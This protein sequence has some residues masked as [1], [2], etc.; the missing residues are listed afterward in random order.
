MA[1]TWRTIQVLSSMQNPSEAFEVYTASLI[2]TYVGEGLIYDSPLVQ[3]VLGGDTSPRDFAV[4]LESE[5]KTSTEGCSEVPLFSSDIYNYA[6]LS[7]AYEKLVNGTAYSSTTLTEL[8]LV[9]VVVD[10]T[11]SLSIQDY[12]VRA[13]NKAGPALL[14]MVTIRSLEFQKYEFVGV[15]NES[16]VELRSVPR[17]PSTES[18]NNVFIAKEHGFY[19]GYEQL[20][21][22][23]TYSLF[24]SIASKSLTHWGWLGESVIADSWA[25]VHCVHCI[26]GLQTVFSLGVLLLVMYQ[27]F[28]T[29]KIWIGDPFASTSTTIFVLRGLLVMATWFVNSFWNLYEFA[30][31]NAAL[32]S[33]SEIVRV[34]EEMVH[35]DVLVHFPGGVILSQNLHARDHRV[36]RAN[37]Q[38]VPAPSPRQRTPTI[39]PKRG[40]YQRKG[41]YRTE[42]QPHELRALDWRRVADALR[43]HLRLQELRVLQGHEVRIRRRRVLLRVRDRERQVLD[44]VQGPARRGDDEAAQ[45]PHRQCARVRGGG[46]R[47]EG[48][49]A[50]GVPGDVP[51]GRPVETERDGA[52]LTIKY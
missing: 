21:I 38:S 26:Y 44:A 10:S 51:L 50:T 17:D 8:E 1:A 14:G 11:V 6:F 22:R 52:A 45:D 3:D 40:V 48:H 24:E 5:T 31:C 15:A 28:T 29:G 37:A 30:L 49:G 43:Y 34:H 25:W 9:T 36:V 32:L 2:S 18:T 20:N 39:K 33:G 12:E 23:Y 41:R 4:F 27:H 35:A 19:D 47:R 42:R 7:Q 13:H 46:E 16:Y